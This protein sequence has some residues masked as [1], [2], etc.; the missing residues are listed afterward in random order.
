MTK[1]SKAITVSI[2][3]IDI[4]IDV[5]AYLRGRIVVTNKKLP[6]PV[7]NWDDYQDR[8]SNQVFSCYI[9]TAGSCCGFQEICQ[10]YVR[11]QPAY[12][13]LLSAIGQKINP[14]LVA[15]GF[16]YLMAY[17]P[18][19]KKY[20]TTRNLLKAA[21]FV[22]AISLPSKHGK[23]KYTNTRWD[24]YAPKFTGKTVKG[25]GNYEAGVSRFA[26]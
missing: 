5:S 16:Q 10:M 25:T 2:D 1:K 21:G 18:D 7:N 20:D 15:K 6:V 3:D 4:L 11:N 9:E 19:Q 22:P 24:W 12:R 13:P 23:G 8:K 17:L 26:V 14:M